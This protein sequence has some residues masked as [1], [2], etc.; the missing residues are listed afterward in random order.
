MIR[1]DINEFREKQWSNF[2]E[3]LDYRNGKQF[4]D[5]FKILIDQK[6]QTTHFLTQNGQFITTPKAPSTVSSLRRHPRNP[7][8]QSPNFN[9]NFFNRVIHDV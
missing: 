8:P 9:K 3:K 5:K 2:G 7:I 6:T 4:W 1:R